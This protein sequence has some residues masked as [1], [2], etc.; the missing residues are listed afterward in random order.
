MLLLDH[1][2]PHSLTILCIPRPTYSDVLIH[3]SL[4]VR[5][6]EDDEIP[7]NQYGNIEVIRGDTSQVPKGAVWVDERMAFKVGATYPTTNNTFALLFS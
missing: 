3:I 1:L 7:T 5:A 2:H 6:V 4:Q